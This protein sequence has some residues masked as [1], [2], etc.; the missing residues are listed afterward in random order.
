MRTRGVEHWTGLV[1][2]GDGLAG[3]VWPCE[4]LRKLEVGPQPVNDFLEAFAKRP[5]LTRALCVMEIGF[6]LWV[7]MRR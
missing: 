7:F 2:V 3:L 6:G 1:M 4:Y 5:A